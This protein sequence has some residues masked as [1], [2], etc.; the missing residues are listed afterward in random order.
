M[1]INL[2]CLNISFG[3]NISVYT[4]LCRLHDDGVVYADD[5][6]VLSNTEDGQIYM[7]QTFAS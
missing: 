1:Q 2:E 7:K 5:T 3:R 4:Q 6:L